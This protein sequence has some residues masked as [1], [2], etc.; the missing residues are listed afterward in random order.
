[1]AGY[2]TLTVREISEANQ[3]LPGVKLGML[4][5]A[6]EIPVADV[7][8]YLHVT[9]VTVYSWFRGQAMVSYRH[10]DMIQKLISKLA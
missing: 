4:C 5:V 7:A 10:M 8:S 6:K 9:R 3:D 1:M 2:S